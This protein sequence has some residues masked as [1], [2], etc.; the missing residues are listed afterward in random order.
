MRLESLAKW[1]DNRLDKVISRRPPDFL[2]GPDKDPYLRRWWIIP[3]NKCFNI[4]LH[5]ML[6]DDDDRALHDHPWWS[7]SIC[8]RGQIIEHDN[9]VFR[10]RLFQ[11]DV[12][13]RDGKTPHRLS[14]PQGQ[15]RT[16]FVTGPRFREWGFH[17][18]QGWRHWKEFTKPGS[19][20]QRGR[21][22]D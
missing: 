12:V 17:C 7:V 16:L 18:P 9:T 14:F 1:L 11:G 2:I 8:L 20:G 4:Y 13:F 10:K 3:R 22:C 15:A 19:P 21:G 5:Q 6:H